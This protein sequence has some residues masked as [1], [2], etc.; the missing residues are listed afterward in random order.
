MCYKLVDD[1]SGMIIC[2]SVI[3]SATEPGTANLWVDPI[4]PLPPDVIHSIN[5]DAMLDEM[6]AA[7]DFDTPFS[8]VNKKDLVGSIPASTKSK[9]WQEM[10][11]DWQLEHQEGIQQRYFHSYQPKST[12]NK[13]HLIPNKI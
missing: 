2:Q 9:T 11:Q 12:K 4:K 7:A 6:M 10:E 1:E 3:Q 13:Q 8:D 5:P